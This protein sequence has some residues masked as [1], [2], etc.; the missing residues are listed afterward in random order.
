MVDVSASF[1]RLERYL[2]ATAYKGYDCYDALNS[3]IL[4]ALSMRNKYL[5]IA[6]IQ[7]FRRLPVNLRPLLLVPKGYNPKGLGLLLSGCSRLCR[8]TGDK[9]YLKKLEHFAML[10]RNFASHGHSGMCW[11]YN[12]DWQSRVFFVPKFTPTIVNTAF[13]AHG[14]LDAYEATKDDAYLHVARSACDFILRDLHRS[15]DPDGSFS[16]SYTPIDVLKVHNA[17]MLGA[18]LLARVFA[19][20]GETELADTARDAVRYVVKHQN[21]D[22]SWYYADTSFQ[23]WIDSFHTGFVLES[24]YVYMQSTGDGAFRDSLKSGFSFFLEN[25]FLDDGMPKYLHNKIYPVD[26]HSSAQGIVS[27]LRLAELDGRSRST[28]D[29]L[30]HWTIAHM[31]DKRGYFY[32]Q[33]HKPYTIKIP[34]V[35]W[36]EAW[37]YHAL[38]WYMTE[39]HDKESYG[40][41]WNLD[42]A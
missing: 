3:P 17:N 42:R 19:C 10:L 24:L 9:K 26:I 31:Q 4:S 40:H 32:Y 15:S 20:T 30:V 1:G 38:A 22:G 5:R 21:Q 8:W 23:R 2:E 11:G 39:T 16:F 12:F 27:L 28:L 37:M 34:Y 36:S 6:F 13:V 14:F 25:F 41:T 7:A 35:R 33:R 18:G 29:K